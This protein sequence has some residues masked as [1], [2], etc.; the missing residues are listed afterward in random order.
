MSF[1]KRGKTNIGKNNITWL[2]DFRHSDWGHKKAK[3]GCRGCLDMNKREGAEQTPRWI[4]RG[5]GNDQW[6]RGRNLH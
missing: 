3:K 1:K 4:P 2:F 5:G 6:T